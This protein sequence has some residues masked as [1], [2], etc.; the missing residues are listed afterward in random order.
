MHVEIE[1]I[2]NRPV[3]IRFNSGIYKHLGPNAIET[4]ILNVEVENNAKIEKLQ[5]LN[6]IALREGG[7]KKASTVSSAKKKTKTIK[8]ANIIKS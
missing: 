4:N 8:K 2:C 3:S 6:I 7:K 1:N 5:K